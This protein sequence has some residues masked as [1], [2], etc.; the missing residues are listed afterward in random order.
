MKRKFLALL[1]TLFVLPFGFIFVGCEFPFFDKNFT[2][3]YPEVPLDETYCA[4]LDHVL[5]TF[6]SN[7][8]EHKDTTHNLYAIAQ[9]YETVAGESRLV[10]YV[11]WRQ[12]NHWWK[13]ADEEYENYDTAITFLNVRIVDGENVINKTFTLENNEWVK[14]EGWFYT[15]ENLYSN[16]GNSDS[17]RFKMTSHLFR[18]SGGTGRELHD[19]YKTATTSDYIEYVCP[20]NEIFRISNNKYN[21]TLKYHFYSVGSEIGSHEEHDANFE[22]GSNSVPH[23]TNDGTTNGTKTVVVPY[24]NTITAAMLAN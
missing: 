4:T 7:D 15:Y 9:K 21:V 8:L 22:P 2:V 14:E 16:I 12:I 3:Y 24:L 1:L 6:K 5:E 13:A 10:T 11:E 17:F 20:G 19:R 18:Y 23:L